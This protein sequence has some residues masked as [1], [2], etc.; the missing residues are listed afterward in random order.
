MAE[1]C[2][3]PTIHLAYLRTPTTVGTHV[4]LAVR[5]ALDTRVF[6]AEG[7]TSLENF[8]RI[9]IFGLLAPASI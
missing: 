7:A 1:N 5:R 6:V 8:V 9:S 2:P 3:P 4:W